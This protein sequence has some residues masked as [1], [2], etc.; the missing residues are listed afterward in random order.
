MLAACSSPAPSLPRRT[1]PVASPSL[2]A[3][4]DDGAVEEHDIV[5]VDA[6]K[7]LS[8]LHLASDREASL[9]ARRIGTLRADGTLELAG[10]QGALVA[11]LETDGRV[12][13]RAA[14]RYAGRY[15]GTLTR[16]ASGPPR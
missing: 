4:P 8:L 15:P 2:A 13:I 1:T 3:A 14:A 5:L 9:G 10:S 16:R 6:E 11:R 7:E 12:A